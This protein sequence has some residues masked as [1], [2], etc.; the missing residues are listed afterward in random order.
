M[1]WEA[2]G[3]VLVGAAVLVG[4][5]LPNRC[6]PPLPNDKL[7]HFAAYAALAWLA[8]RL[9]TGGWALTAVVVALGVAGWLIECLQNLVPDRKFS[10]PDLLANGAGVAAGALL[11]QAGT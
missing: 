11:A 6:L 7:L 8:A 10:W 2:L 1:P 9:V 3:L 5:L 4:S